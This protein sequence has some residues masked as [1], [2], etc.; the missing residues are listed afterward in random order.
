MTVKINKELLSENKKIYTREEL[1]N[2][3]QFL[4]TRIRKDSQVDEMYVAVNAAL[5]YQVKDIPS[6]RK[7]FPKITTLTKNKK[8]EKEQTTYVEKLFQGNK[9]MLADLLGVPFGQMTD[10]NLILN[11]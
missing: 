4:P 9:K 5:P 3:K 6:S 11:T 1:T 10:L 7:I 8:R 2:K